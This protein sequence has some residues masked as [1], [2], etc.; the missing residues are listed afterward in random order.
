MYHSVF[1]IYSIVITTF[2]GRF[3]HFSH[4]TDKEIE[5]Q[6]V[7]QSG[8]RVILSTTVMFRSEDAAAPH[9]A[10]ITINYHS[11]IPKRMYRMLTTCLELR[12]Q[13]Q[14]SDW[15]DQHLWRG[16]NRV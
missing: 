6:K 11:F 8:S 7:R 16:A 10:F 5:A 4:L 2:Q 1:Y 13:K 3:Y 14:K 12:T 9:F 15:W